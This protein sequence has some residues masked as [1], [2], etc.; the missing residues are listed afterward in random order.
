MDS[1]FGI[2]SADTL[3]ADALTVAAQLFREY[4]DWLGIDLSFQGFEAELAGLPGAYAPPTGALLLA[5]AP[6]GQP[7]GCVAIRKLHEAGTCE[8]KRLYTR[9]NARG[10]GVGRALAEAAIQAAVQA[11]YQTMRLDTLPSMQAAVALYRDLGFET[12]PA[13]YETPVSE[14][15]FM[16]KTLTQP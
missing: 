7:V 12:T 5:Y 11:G 8:M 10:A 16:R 6:D 14:T 4:V 2:R 3:P 1:A 15:I 9:P 13:Y